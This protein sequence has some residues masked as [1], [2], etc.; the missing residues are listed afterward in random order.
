MK[1][2]AHL[3]TLLLL[4][5]LCLNASAQSLSVNSFRQFDLSVN[6]SIRAMEV[7]NDSVV[8][9][10][11]SH[12]IYGFTGNAGKT[13]T[14][15]SIKT[16]SLTPEFRSIAVL[17]DHTEL[18]LN[19][20]SPA[21]IRKSDDMGVTWRVVY[22]NDEDDIFFDVLKFSDEMN[23]IAVSD[24]VGKCFQII[25]THDGG[26]TWQPVLCSAITPA[27]NGEV[28]FASSNTSLDVSGKL[29]WLGTGGLHS[30]VLASQ[31]GGNHWKTIE[32]PIEEGKEL[33]GIFSIDFYDGYT[34]I[35]AGGDYNDKSSKIL[36]VAITRDAGETWKKIDEDDSPPFV[37]CVQYQ[38]NSNGGVIMACC[39]PGIYFTEDGGLHWR[40]LK[41]EKG[42]EFTESFFTFRFSPSGKAAWFAGADGKVARLELK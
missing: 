19:T 31:D 20:G 13:W 29:A 2:P 4:C 40:K 21:Y 10:A 1:L 5:E 15:D 36:T 22:K 24:P 23:G 37:S 8:W 7:L 17:N 39:L 14:I 16:D 41:N 3:L 27:L 18:V 26:E 30:R 33:T 9:F 35:I 34:G 6:T 38:P 11:G 12:G 25:V 32:A 42:K 28:C